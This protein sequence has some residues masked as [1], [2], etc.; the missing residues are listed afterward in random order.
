MVESI[1]APQ[2]STTYPLY[3]VMGSCRRQMKTHNLLPTLSFQVSN[4]ECT[5]I[6]NLYWGQP[7]DYLLVKSSWVG[8]LPPGRTHSQPRH[9]MMLHNVPAVR[10]AAWGSFHCHLQT[11]FGTGHKS[12]HCQ[13]RAME[14]SLQCWRCWYELLG[15]GLWVDHGSLHLNFGTPLPH[16]G[17]IPKL[18]K[19]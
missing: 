16:F 7:H 10:D 1:F 12:F 11:G 17:Y 19:L 13:L 18:Y 8:N 2:L 14:C 5:H 3:S 15:I 4:F 9:T 6:L